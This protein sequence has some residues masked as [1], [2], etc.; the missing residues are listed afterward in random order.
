MENLSEAP[1]PPITPK[2]VHIPLEGQGNMESSLSFLIG[3]QR[4]Q[5]KLIQSMSGKVNCL[6][7][8]ELPQKSLQGVGDEEWVRK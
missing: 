1:P 4:Q 2:R 6:A 8:K 7:S 5:E 3:G